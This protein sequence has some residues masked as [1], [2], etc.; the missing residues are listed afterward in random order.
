VL[1]THVVKTFLAI[2]D[3]RI[4][5]VEKAVFGFSGGLFLVTHDAFYDEHKHVRAREAGRRK[6]MGAL[7]R[8]S[9]RGLWGQIAAARHATPSPSQTKRIGELLPVSRVGEP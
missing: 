7:R 4:H 2:P 1:A 8:P 9:P 3:H 5:A 6:R